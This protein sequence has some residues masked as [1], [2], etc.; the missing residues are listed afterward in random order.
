MNKVVVEI[1]KA[2]N[3]YSGLGQFCIHLG[4][5]LQV[6]QPEDAELEFA[7]SK[8]A[9][10]PVGEEQNYHLI[11]NIQRYTGIQAGQKSV[12]HTTHQDSPFVP[13]SGPKVLLT[14]HDLNFLEKYR[15]A[16][17]HKWRLRLIQNKINRSSA[18]VTISEFTA[19]QVREH[20]N[21]R[22]KPLHVIYNGCVQHPG[23]SATP[24]Q[25]VKGNFLFTIGVLQPRKNIEVL[26]PLMKMLPDFKLVVSGN[27]QPKYGELLHHLVDQ[28]GLH[29]RIIFTGPVTDAEKMWYY[30]NC[31]AFVFPSRSEGFGL[32]V[33]EAM[34]AGKPVFL[35]TSTCL[36]EIG[37]KEAFYWNTFDPAQMKDVL[38]KGLSSWTPEKQQLST[39]WAGRFSWENAAQH[40]WEVYKSL[41]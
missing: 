24:M 33:I 17:R 14:I 1:D 39:Q 22:D 36:P 37:G 19:N 6:Y 21:L 9:G 40:Y 18:V 28:A 20:L 29:N 32:P 41:L 7:L 10:K 31:T 30:N 3:P 16:L 27:A 23:P 12:W 5:Q 11:K 15:N 4:K 8:K 2:R 13:K 26:I 38:L 25:P 34:N 35:S